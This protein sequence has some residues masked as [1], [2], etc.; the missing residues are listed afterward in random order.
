MDYDIVTLAIP[1]RNETDCK[2]QKYEC[3]EHA[4]MTQRFESKFAMMSNELAMYKLRWVILK[5]RHP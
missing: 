5:N 3:D 1:H 4:A 2:W